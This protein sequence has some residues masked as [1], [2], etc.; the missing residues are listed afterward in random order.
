M[1]CITPWHRRQEFQHDGN[2]EFDFGFGEVNRFRVSVI[3]ARGN[4]AM[5]LRQIPKKKPNLDQQG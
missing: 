2:T 3:R 1:E 4:V 5:V